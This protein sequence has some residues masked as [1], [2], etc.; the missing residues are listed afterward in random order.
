MSGNWLD[1][2]HEFATDI[3]GRA[4]EAVRNLKGMK[5]EVF[6]TSDQTMVRALV[7]GY[8]LSQITVELVKTLLT[9]KCV[10]GED[11]FARSVYIPNRPYGEP[12]AFLSYGLLTVAFPHVEKQEKEVKNIPIVQ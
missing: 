7:P 11:I 4:F 8:E 9:I 6:E 1:N 12:R 3:G 5:V 10:R 2:I